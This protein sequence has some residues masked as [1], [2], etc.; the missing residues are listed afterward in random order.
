MLLNP[1]IF[2]R[3]DDPLGTLIS[4]DSPSL[5]WRMD[6]TSGTQATDASG[7][8]RHGTHAG[9]APPATPGAG[10]LVASG[11]G[12]STDYGGNDYTTRAAEAWMQSLTALTV[13]CIARLDSVSG[14]RILVARDNAQA[15][16]TNRHWTLRMEDGLFRSGYWDATVSASGGDRTTGFSGLTTNVTYMF[17]MTVSGTGLVHKTFLN[18]APGAS[19]TLPGPAK[20][21]NTPQPLEVGCYNNNGSR[22]FYLDGRVSEVAVFPAELTPARLAEYQAARLAA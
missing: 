4:A 19:Y 22:G 7:S 20:S 9:T 12:S 5:W 14:H 6:D 2:A 21:H 17:A 11:Y 8:N 1:Y 3:D 13:I 15:S 18:G 16:T 10:S